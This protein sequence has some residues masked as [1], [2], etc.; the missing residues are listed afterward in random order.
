MRIN[1]WYKLFKKQLTTYYK[2]SIKINIRVSKLY[3]Q[4]NLNKCI[5]NIAQCAVG[6]W[7]SVEWCS[8]FIYYKKIFLQSTSEDINLNFC[9]NYFLLM[10]F[11]FLNKTQIFC[12]I[13]WLSGELHFKQ[14]NKQTSKR[15]KRT[16]LFKQSLQC[17][18]NAFFMEFQEYTFNV[19]RYFRVE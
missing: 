7:C 4:A 2:P 10:K 1:S 3:I 8:M 13:L 15:K 19:Y 16:N 6:L 14:I 17:Q 9:F 5:Y 12:L 18:T 11:N